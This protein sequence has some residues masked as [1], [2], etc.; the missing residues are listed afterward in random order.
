MNVDH[1]TQK[2]RTSNAQLA[3]GWADLLAFGEFNVGF[4]HIHNPSGSPFTIDNASR[5]NWPTVY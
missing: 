4:F 2:G 1:R 5:A 3:I